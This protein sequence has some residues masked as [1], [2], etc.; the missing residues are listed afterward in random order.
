MAADLYISADIE[1]DGPIPG[2]YSMLAFGLAVAGRFDGRSFEPRDPTVSTF[3][4]E[5]RPISEKFDPQA[6]VVNGLDRE[7]LEREGASP[8]VALREA[9]DWVDVQAGGDRP[10]FV[11]YPIVFDWL[12]MHW[13]FVTFLG[14]SPF[15]FSGALDMK[16]IYQQKARV[17]LDGAGRDDLPSFLHS[18]HQHTHHALDDAIEQAEIFANLFD[19]RG[20]EPG[21]DASL[22]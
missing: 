8:A 6:L 18:Q 3:Y 13:Y 5:L 14:R 21:G 20:F 1:A 2:E 9:S 12:F 11:G 17:T 16:T 22:V 4:R 7:R 15:G 10:V 19:W